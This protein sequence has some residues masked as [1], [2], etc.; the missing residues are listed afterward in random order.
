MNEKPPAKWLTGWKALGLSVLA[1]AL[2]SVAMFSWYY[3]STADLVRVRAEAKALGIPTT[4][5]ETG[6]V[7]S[8]PEVVEIYKRIGALSASLKDYD[9]LV[10]LGKVGAGKADRL[11]PY[12]PIPQAAFDH[13][14]SLDPVIISEYLDL[15]DRLPRE[16]V[17]L[18]GERNLSTRH[19]QIG[20]ARQIVRYQGERILL[21]TPDQVAREVDRALHYLESQGCHSLSEFIMNASHIEDILGQTS[22]R[23]A[24]IKSRM[25]ELADRLDRLADS[26]STMQ[27][28][29]FVGEFVIM[30]AV[31]EKTDQIAAGWTDSL[32]SVCGRFTYA[33]QQIFFGPMVRAG[34]ETLLRHEIDWIQIL[35][36][37]PSPT[38]LLASAKRIRVE[39]K[40]LSSWMPNEAL[41]KMIIIAPPIIFEQTLQCQLRLRLMAAELRGQPWPIDPYDPSGKPLRPFLR[42]GKLMGAYSVYVNGVDDGG[43]RGKDRYFPLYGPL[44]APV[45]VTE[46]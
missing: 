10:Q 46:P 25:P 3:Y 4:W 42:D 27:I 16:P 5:A 8:S 30:N 9:Y 19:P 40:K 44:E 45:T 34:R 20:W 12:L 35:Q 1:F 28:K 43:A 36:R 29:F 6:I 21:A 23:F 14:A 17:V 38:E 7:V 31:I 37:H 26:M 39:G 32:L 41:I 13:H 18:T 22:G 2:I 11:K 33:W 15:M 24:E